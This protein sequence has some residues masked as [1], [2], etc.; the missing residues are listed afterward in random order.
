MSTKFDSVKYVEPFL[1]PRSPLGDKLR[2]IRLHFPE[3][4]TLVLKGLRPR[5]RPSVFWSPGFRFL[6]SLRVLINRK[7]IACFARSV[8]N[9]A[10]FWLTRERG[11]TSGMIITAACVS[12]EIDPLPV[13]N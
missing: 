12:L 7:N 11:A 9:F 13:L 2:R 3:K 4:G 6:K 10:W 5:W 8:H 1:Q